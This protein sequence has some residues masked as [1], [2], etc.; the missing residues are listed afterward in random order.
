MKPIPLIA[1][2]IR[3]SSMTNCIVLDPFGGS[4]STLI[5]CEQTGRIC[6]TIELDEKYCDVI[7]KRY[8]EQAKSAAEV[9]V[10]REWKKIPYAELGIESKNKSTK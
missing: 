7:V 10:V 4:G 1:Y 2:P 5:A 6:R 8:I 3:N 9:Y